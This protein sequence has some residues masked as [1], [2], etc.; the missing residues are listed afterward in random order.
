MALIVIT[1]KVAIKVKI[2]EREYT[3]LGFTI[4]IKAIT[5]ERICIDLNLDLKNVLFITEN[6][7]NNVALDAEIGKFKKNKYIIIGIN[8]IHKDIFLL[9]LNNDNILL[10]IIKNNEIWKPDI[11]NKCTIFICIAIS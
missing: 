8:A 3:D 2:N 9:T 4:N 7:T 1:T 6:N 11:T 5:N 10:I